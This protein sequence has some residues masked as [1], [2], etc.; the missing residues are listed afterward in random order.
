[1]HQIRNRNQWE[2]SRMW[3][4]VFALHWKRHKPFMRFEDGKTF[5][6]ACLA[7]RT[8][9]QAGRTERL[10][11]A[12]QHVHTFRVNIS[13][14]PLA[15]GGELDRTGSRAP[16]H[17]W[18][19]LGINRRQPTSKAR[20]WTWRAAARARTFLIKTLR[21]INQQIW[22]Y[23]SSLTRLLSLRADIRIY[24]TGTFT[25]AWCYSAC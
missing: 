20:W 4:W 15:A 6:R 22:P 16:T 21:S 17:L 13:H 5:P 19:W 8:M 9:I 25:S 11:L 14:K 3:K 2:K 1:M 23:I 10:Y 12:E 24:V 7:A 18:R